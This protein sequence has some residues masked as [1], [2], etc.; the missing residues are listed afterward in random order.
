MR[1]LKVKRIVFFHRKSPKNIRNQRLACPTVSSRACGPT[2]KTWVVPAVGAPLGFS[3][4]VFS[5]GGRLFSSWRFA[6]ARKK[7][8]G[9]LRGPRSAP[10]T[11]NPRGA[12]VAAATP[13]THLAACS[14]PLWY[15]DDLGLACVES[16]YLSLN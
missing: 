13:F 8:F 5:F 14:G 2:A 3:A 1:P 7:I 6:P 12:G 4:Q 15:W 16:V 11:E 10:E 9:P